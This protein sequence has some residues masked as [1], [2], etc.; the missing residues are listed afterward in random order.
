MAR[1][2]FMDSDTVSSSAYHTDTFL[3][4]PKGDIAILL[5]MLLSGVLYGFMFIGDA[6]PVSIFIFTVYVRPNSES[7]LANRSTFWLTS[8][9]TA[10]DGTFMSVLTRCNII[11]ESWK[12]RTGERC[13]GMSVMIPLDFVYNILL[14]FVF[15]MYVDVTWLSS[16]CIVLYLK[17]TSGR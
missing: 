4:L 5:N 6:S 8:L 13:F 7:F 3:L 2:P 1:G 12:L 17:K 15:Y 10:S 16:L 11:L 9:S 14:Y